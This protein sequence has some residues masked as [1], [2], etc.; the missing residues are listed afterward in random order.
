VKEKAK[1]RERERKEGGRESKRDKKNNREIEQERKVTF[2]YE[3][4]KF[5]NAQIK[6]QR[7]L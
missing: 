7:Q 6:W 3:F 5:S 2:L 4:F 1:G